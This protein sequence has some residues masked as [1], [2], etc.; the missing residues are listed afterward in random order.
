MRLKAGDA[1]WSVEAVYPGGAAERAEVRLGDTVLTISGKPR[2]DLDETILCQVMTGPTGPRVDLRLR[3]E[4][5]EQSISL[6]L[7]GVL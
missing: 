1:G 2:A 3:S 5:V 4:G 6:R 7:R